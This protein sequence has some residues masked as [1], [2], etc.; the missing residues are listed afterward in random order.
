MKV[1]A[2]AF[3]AGVVFGEGS[4]GR[5]GGSVVS[6]GTLEP[7]AGAFV[8]VD[9]TDL[10]AITDSEGG[11]TILSVPVGSYG[12]RVSA[13]GHHPGLASDVIVR[14]GRLTTV[15]L[16]LERAPV[17]GGTITVRPSYFSGEDDRPGSSQ[18]FTGEEVRRAPGSAGD[19]VRII[20]GLPSVSKVD[21]Q[22]NGLAVRGG[23]PFENGIY[24]ENM[25]MGN[26][27][28]F[29]RQGT[30]GGGLSMVNVDVLSDVRFSAGG[31]GSRFGDRLS[32]VMELDLRSGNR[33]E[34][35]GQLD[36]GMAGAGTV[37]EGPL[38]G[39]SGSW[40]VTARHSWV[41]LLADIADIDAVPVYSDFMVKTE[42]DL[43]SEHRLTFLGLGAFDYVDY[44]WEQAW[45]DGN[46]NYGVTRNS[47]ILS[48]VNWRWLWEGEGFSETSLSFTA[49]SYGGDYRRTVGGELE[50]VQDSRERA[51]RLRNMNTWQAS[52]ALEIGFGTETTFRFDA[53][54]NFYGA[55]T[56]W[57]GEPLP[58]LSVNRTVE[59]GRGGVFA[60]ASLALSPALT[61]TA[62]IRGDYSGVRDAVSFSPRGSASL[63]IG[64]GSTL[65][66]S[67]G[68]YR[69]ALPDELTARDPAYEELDEP[70]AV[71]AVL[72]WR[73]LMG[74]DIR[75][76]IEAYSKEYSNFPY[77]PEQPGF[78]ILDGLGSEQDLYTFSSL[79][80]GAEA[81]S[82]GLEVT[83]HKRLAMG[84][85]GI[86][87]GSWSSTSYR[88]PGESSRRRIYDNRLMVGIEGGYKFDERWEASVRWDYAGG[89]PYTPLDPEASA[90]YNRTILDDSRINAERLP[91]YHSLNLRVD[92]RF[93]FSRTALVTYASIWNVYNRRNIAAVY[94]NGV[95]RSEDTI[96]QWGM[97]P[98]IGLEYEF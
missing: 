83:L 47:S 29:P 43:S 34:F 32:S 97:M 95:T 48:G 27:N 3:F 68:V 19:V 44:T 1:L 80:S 5:I 42:L 74:E 13:V 41:S 66:A 36:F 56:T 72:G 84:L 85:Y 89:R 20:A 75:L 82:R 15:D 86:V 26:I 81:V 23:N 2:V 77:D 16:V 46:P 67:A 11:Y 64:E 63:L 71:H 94:W 88:N 90:L 96:L 8:I 60:E 18:D 59:H 92:R 93:H 9:G 38:P 61:V 55:D 37:L 33:E 69:Q 10:G 52:G 79:E 73:K 17:E 57:S 54:D 62:G 28:H 12:L 30:S 21:N 53:F 76:V 70:C 39:A 7:V 65:T 51:L 98:V 14:S 78:F 35:D 87:S 49:Q 91:A 24:L 4:G 31:F 25:E 40:L 50:A 6:S 22:Y 58:P 45:D